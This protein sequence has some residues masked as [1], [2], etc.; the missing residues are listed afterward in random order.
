[1]NIL[2]LNSDFNK[3]FSQINFKFSLPQRR[4]LST[5]V[6]GFYLLLQKVCLVLMVRKLYLISV[7]TQCFQRIEVH[8]INF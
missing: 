8:L 5:F 4:H 1:M 2:S 3:Y 6:E 7:K